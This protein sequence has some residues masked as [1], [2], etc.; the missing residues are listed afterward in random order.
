MRS[1]RGSIDARGITLR[2]M[3]RMTEI[4]NREHILENYPQ[5][6]FDSVQGAGR[7]VW[8]KAG[9]RGRPG[10]RCLDARFPS[11]HLRPNPSHERRFRHAL[12][13]PWTEL[14]ET[15]VSLMWGIRNH[16]SS[17]HWRPAEGHYGPNTCR[18][19]TLH[20]IL[21]RVMSEST[22]GGRFTAS[23]RRPAGRGAFSQAMLWYLC[24]TPIARCR[25]SASACLVCVLEC[26]D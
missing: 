21:P 17:G 15:D 9:C 5:R 2:R 20:R 26:R 7:R 22:H 13:D 8:S 19:R 23:V 25:G 3:G 12:P 14:D 16:G 1:E 11:S 6:R 4:G 24:A 10:P 18:A